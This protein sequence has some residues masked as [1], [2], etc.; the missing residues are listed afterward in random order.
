MTH[1]QTPAHEIPAHISNE[2]NELRTFVSAQIRHHERLTVM[3]RKC[4]LVVKCL[5]S[6]L[7]VITIL[8]ASAANGWM[9]PIVQNNVTAAS[10]V[11]TFIS[12]LH[13][14]TQLN[15]HAQQC[16]NTVLD[17]KAVLQE[18]DT[19]ENHIIQL[20][21]NPAT[22][23]QMT[24]DVQIRVGHFLD[25]AG[26]ASILS[27]METD[28]ANLLSHTIRNCRSELIRIVDMV[29]TRVVMLPT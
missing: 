17:L 19:V 5:Q 13:V 6:S 27:R 14:W 3:W 8:T 28:T 25:G 4:L 29:P 24:Y 23:Q 21:A 18:V 9:P 26:M 22:S 10:A 7:G 11:F 2:M 16:F 20:T 12:G 1:P 15:T